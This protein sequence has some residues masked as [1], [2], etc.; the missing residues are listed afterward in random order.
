MVLLQWKPDVSGRETLQRVD[1]FHTYVRP[2]WQ[3]ILTEFCTALTGI[4]QVRAHSCRRR[5]LTGQDMVDRSPT[6]PEMVRLLETWM[7]KHGLRD[8]DGRLQDAV[9]VT[10]GV[11][12]AGR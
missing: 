5:S 1:T 3:P 12:L 11:S 2:T 10:D 8:E 6:F 4:T 9:W 7:D